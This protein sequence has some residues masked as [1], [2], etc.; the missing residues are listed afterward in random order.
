MMKDESDARIF[1]IHHS[2]LSETAPRWLE[3]FH[4]PRERVVLAHRSGRLKAP[5]P[6]RKDAQAENPESNLVG[7]NAHFP[8]RRVTNPTCARYGPC[9]R[10]P[11]AA[12]RS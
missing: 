6:R 11:N 7:S 10:R 8:S 9:R 2:S 4:D 5:A 12:R 3:D 1:I